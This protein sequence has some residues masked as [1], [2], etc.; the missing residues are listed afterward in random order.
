MTAIP[1]DKQPLAEH[2][3][4]PPAPCSQMNVE[5]SS[6]MKFL[7]CRFVHFLIKIPANFHIEVLQQPD[8]LSPCLISILSDSFWFATGK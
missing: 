6:N 5:G 2:A 4:K 1:V 7:N 8:F 3:E